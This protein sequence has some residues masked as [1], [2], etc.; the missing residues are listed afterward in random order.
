MKHQNIVLFYES[1][2]EGESSHSYDQ[3]VTMTELQLQEMYGSHNFPHR[4]RSSVTLHEDLKTIE[5]SMVDSQAQ[6]L[7]A[8]RRKHCKRKRSTIRIPNLENIEEDELL[9][10]T[11]SLIEDKDK[12]DFAAIHRE[13]ALSCTA[14]LQQQNDGRR[15]RHKKFTRIRLRSNST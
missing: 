13:R 4:Y 9:E 3:P 7:S 15:F 1:Y 14:A 11:A 6:R 2:S 5:K 10:S 8:A 12:R